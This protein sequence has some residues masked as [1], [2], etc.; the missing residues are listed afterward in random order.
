MGAKQSVAKELESVKEIN[1]VNTDAPKEVKPGETC[2]LFMKSKKIEGDILFKNEF[3]KSVL[4]PKFIQSLGKGKDKIEFMIPK[5]CS[6]E[7]EMLQSKKSSDKELEVINK[8]NSKRGL[9]YNSF[10]KTKGVKM[11]VTSDAEG[12]KFATLP[13][14]VRE[15]GELQTIKLTG[16]PA[17]GADIPKHKHILSEY[18]KTL[19]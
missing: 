17:K 9:K 2:Q 8:A 1:P 4:T 3:D 11:Y 5:G 19:G 15:F 10:A 7:F 16:T 12:N 14:S 13:L 6:V 18:V